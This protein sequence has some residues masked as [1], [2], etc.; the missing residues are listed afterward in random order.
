MI[1]LRSVTLKNNALG[2][3]S[4]ITGIHVIISL[5]TLLDIKHNHGFEFHIPPISSST[6]VTLMEIG[7]RAVMCSGLRARIQ[8]SNVQRFQRLNHNMAGQ[9]FFLGVFCALLSSLSATEAKT[10]ALEMTHEQRDLCVIRG[11]AGTLFY[12]EI[13]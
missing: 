6:S 3:R 1:A 8:G 9:V 2:L 10:T 4:T 5:C 13:L 12:F 7:D 11:A